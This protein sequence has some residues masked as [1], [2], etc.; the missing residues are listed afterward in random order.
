MRIQ[1]A[2]VAAAMLAATS[3]AFAQNADNLF[4]GP[5][6]G[7]GVGALNDNVDGGALYDDQDQWSGAFTGF[8]GYD[9]KYEI[10]ASGRIGYLVRPDVLVYARGGYANLRGEFTPVSGGASLNTDIDGWLAGGGVEYAFY[11][12]LSARAEYRYQDLGKGDYDVERNQALIGVTYR[13]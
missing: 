7:V 1:S 12:N 11:K 2:S 4:E 9:P 13:F 3:P 6:V 5:Y 10:N 8:V